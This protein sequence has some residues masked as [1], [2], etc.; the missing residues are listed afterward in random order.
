[1]ENLGRQGPGW[2]WGRVSVLWTKHS[3]WEE[4]AGAGWAMAEQPPVRTMNEGGGGEGW[5]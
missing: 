3:S 4:A 2:G 5:I 1:M